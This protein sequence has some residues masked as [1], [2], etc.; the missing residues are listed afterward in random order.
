MEV[1][2]HGP[3]LAGALLEVLGLARVWEALGRPREAFRGLMVC[4]VWE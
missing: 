3:F 2:V 1:G 4:V